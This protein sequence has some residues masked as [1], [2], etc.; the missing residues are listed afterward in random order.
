MRE[1]LMLR[2]KFRLTILTKTREKPA[3]S[4]GCKTFAST[5]EGQ[6]VVHHAHYRPPVRRL[7]GSRRSCSDPPR[8]C[9]GS[10]ASFPIYWTI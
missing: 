7:D 6:P 9:D 5:G 3:A 4:T 10:G 1:I 2:A 8:A